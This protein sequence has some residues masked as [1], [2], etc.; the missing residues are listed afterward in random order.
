MKIFGV[1]EKFIGLMQEAR[2]YKPINRI[3]AA[4]EPAA[5]PIT[6]PLL[7]QLRIYCYTNKIEIPDFLE[8]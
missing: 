4:S 3:Q 5:Y 8:G 2:K 6:L 1:S 7:D